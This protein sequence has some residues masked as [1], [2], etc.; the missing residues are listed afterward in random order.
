M[1][2]KIMKSLSQP[3]LPVTPTKRYQPD[4]LDMFKKQMENKLNLNPE[5]KLPPLNKYEFKRQV[6]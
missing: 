5:Q 4:A 6:T 2:V 1:E 3:K